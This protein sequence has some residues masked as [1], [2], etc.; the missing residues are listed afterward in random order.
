LEEMTTCL[1]IC[2][3]TSHRLSP[4]AT[5]VPKLGE[6]MFRYGRYTTEDSIGLIAGSVRV[7]YGDADDWC[8]PLFVSFQPAL[9][10]GRTQALSSTYEFISTIVW[11]GQH[12]SFRF[13]ISP[14]AHFT[15]PI[16][17]KRWR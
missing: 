15:N 7:H 17:E 9:Y 4:Y 13:A 3:F 1:L 2:T 12:F 8:Q 10:S 5:C 6:V 14:T 11:Q 16:V